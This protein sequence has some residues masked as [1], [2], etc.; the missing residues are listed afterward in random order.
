MEQA[1]GFLSSYCNRCIFFNEPVVF[2]A[3]P[4]IDFLIQKLE[5]KFV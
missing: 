1:Q 3:V 4:V 5:L 2:Y